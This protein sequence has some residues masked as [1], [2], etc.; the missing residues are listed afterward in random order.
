M[1]WAALQWNYSGKLH[2]PSVTTH[3]SADDSQDLT[4]NLYAPMTIAWRGANGEDEDPEHENDENPVDL[5]EDL[6]EER[7]QVR[8]VQ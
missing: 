7:Q 1:Q 3:H 8:H 5:L 4:Q 6:G 2:V